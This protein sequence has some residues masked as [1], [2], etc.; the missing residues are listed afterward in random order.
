MKADSR[1]AAAAVTAMLLLAVNGWGAEAHATSSAETAAPRCVT[2]QL[3]A[4]IGR[5]DPG[6][7]QRNADLSLT[8]RSA[9]TCS[10]YGFVG[11]IMIDGRGDA[12][13]TRVR[14]DR[15]TPH[16]VT[17]NPGRSAQAG[18][19]WGVIQTGGE[20]TCPTAARLMIIPPDESAHL[21]IP[22]TATVCD[23]GRIDVAPLR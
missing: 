17:L 7:G 13:R 5:I 20:K 14:R 15:V 9:R 19:H 8:N 23:D 22:F 2:G 6:A 3:R 1:L 4:S 18:L 21:E 12:L 11:L 16:R 10:L